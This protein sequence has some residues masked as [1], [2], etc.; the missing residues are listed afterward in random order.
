MPTAAEGG[1]H[2][3]EIWREPR[4]WQPVPS[5]EGEL[6]RGQYLVWRARWSL[7]PVQKML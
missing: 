7:G 4:L 6:W 5:E 2:P 3:Q 1:L